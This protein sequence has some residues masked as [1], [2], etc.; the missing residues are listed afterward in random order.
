MYVAFVICWCYFQ[1]LFSVSLNVNH[2]RNNYYLL[3]TSIFCYR[4]I[5]LII[6]GY[7]APLD[8]YAE[9]NT[10]ASNPA[11]H[12]LAASKDVNVCVGKEWYRFPS[13]FFMPSERQRTDYMVDAF[14][15]KLEIS[16]LFPCNPIQGMGCKSGIGQKL[17]YKQ[18]L[19]LDSTSQCPIYQCTFKVHHLAS[20]CL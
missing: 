20:E 3:C 11:I 13:N 18:T 7:H 16:R 15:K 9:L 14:F 17:A 8:V 5:L 1:F 2:L 12:S 19:L 6:P 10:I 4:Y